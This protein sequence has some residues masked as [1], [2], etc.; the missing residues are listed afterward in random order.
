M[1]TEKGKNASHGTDE[2]SGTDFRPLT[3]LPSTSGGETS[4]A[5]TGIPQLNRQ[6]GDYEIIAELGRGGMGVVFKA[7]QLSLNRLVAIKMVIAQTFTNEEESLR[8]RREAEL[9]AALNHPNIVS[10]YEVGEFEG[11]SFYSMEYIEGTTLY[12]LVRDK[13]L[14][15]TQATRVA[16]VIAEAMQYAHEC[17]VLC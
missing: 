10:I 12:E 5:E 1:N 6:I 14:E 11:H 3:D 7:R 2:L 9:I 16:Q 17:G 13:P 15:W 4:P 8:F